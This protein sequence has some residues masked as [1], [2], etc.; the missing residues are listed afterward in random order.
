[1]LMSYGPPGRV[2]AAARPAGYL[3]PKPHRS[4][5]KISGTRARATNDYQDLLHELVELSDEQLEA[6]SH[7]H[8]DR[9]SF[10][11]LKWLATEPHG[12]LEDAADTLGARLTLL[13]IA[14]SHV[15]PTA[16]PAPV[17][18]DELADEDKAHPV[19][20]GA[21]PRGLALSPEA[22]AA[23]Q[24]QAEAFGSQLG[25][26]RAQAV[27]EIL[28]RKILD[29]G[30]GGYSGPSDA[31]RILDVLL[32]VEEREER[33][34]LAAD[35]CSPAPPTTPVPADEEDV[36]STTPMAL[37]QAVAAALK[38]CQGDAARDSSVEAGRLRELQA[39][40]IQLWNKESSHS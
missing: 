4:C 10:H 37:L 35:A 40:L 38:A 5:A 6:W 17:S 25:I 30:Q 20:L 27:L 23:L 9:I 33:R 39:D 7:S 34:H 3:T 32:E 26:K 24:A 18:K 31:E 16:L 22:F 14:S 29:G 19:R 13:Q 36:V 11:F 1:M 12:P 2:F 8:A 21:P 28:G 15:E